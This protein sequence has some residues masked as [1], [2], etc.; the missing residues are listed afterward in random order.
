MNF[1]YISM[2]FE[3]LSHLQTFHYRNWWN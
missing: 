2:I 3:T 1:N